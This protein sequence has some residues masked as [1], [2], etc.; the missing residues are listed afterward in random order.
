MWTPSPDNQSYRY[1]DMEAL[2]EGMGTGLLGPTRR[3]NLPG[4]AEEGSEVER[5]GKS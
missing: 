2:M 5:K 1:L 3:M 4:V